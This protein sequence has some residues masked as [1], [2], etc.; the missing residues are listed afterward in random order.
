MKT[1]TK[2]FKCFFDNFFWFIVKILPILVLLLLSINDNTVTITSI[3]TNY[4]GIYDNNI[5][6]VV[7]TELFGSSSSFLATYTNNGLLMY[8][9]Y[10]VMVTLLHI[11]VD[12]V[13]LLPDLLHN[14]IER[15]EGGC[16]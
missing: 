11:V 7:F 16:D 6:L 13:K 2:N 8:M 3:M 4:F 14:F 9:V 5:I 10:Y 12:F 15:L 1:K